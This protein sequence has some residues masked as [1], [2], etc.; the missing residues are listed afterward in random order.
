MAYWM[1]VFTMLL[2]TTFVLPFSKTIEP[3]LYLLTVT[4]SVFTE[5]FAKLMNLTV[6]TSTGMP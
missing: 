3:S 6:E 5:S 2:L 4:H 1:V